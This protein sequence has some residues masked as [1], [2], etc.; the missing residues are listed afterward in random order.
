MN[1]LIDKYIEQSESYTKEGI[2]KVNVEMLLTNFTK[3]L[4]EQGYEVSN[5][6]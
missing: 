6:N 3:W 4:K 1:K 2:Y 5:N